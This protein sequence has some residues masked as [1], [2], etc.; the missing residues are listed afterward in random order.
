MVVSLNFVRGDILYSRHV[1]VCLQ[2][3]QFFPHGYRPRK[4]TRNAKQTE[5]KSIWYQEYTVKFLDTVLKVKLFEK[6]KKK[7]CVSL[8]VHLLCVA[9]KLLCTPKK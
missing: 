4:N 5:Y 7:S 9:H 6:V 2:A 1:K 8:L 3:A